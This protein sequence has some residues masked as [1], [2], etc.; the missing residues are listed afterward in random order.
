MLSVVGEGMPLVY[1][2]Q[3]AGNTKRL[4]FFE[5][6]PIVWKE[7]PNGELYRKLFALKKRNTALVERQWGA[8]MILVPNSVPAQGVQLRPPQRHGQGFRRASISPA[9]RRR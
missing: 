1:N 5:K 8:T 3:E 7:H 4:E 2:G 9:S 6:D